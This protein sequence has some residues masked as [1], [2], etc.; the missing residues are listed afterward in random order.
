MPEGPEIRLS[1]DLLADVLD[2]EVIEKISFGLPKLQRYQSVFEGQQITKVENHGKAML[3]HF[4]NGVTIY[5]HNQL[6]G[7][8]VVTQ[9][10]ILPQT[11]RQLRLALHT[12]SHSALLYSA[13]DI[14][15][16]PTDELS[17][18]PFLKKL[19]PDILATGL[20]WQAIRERLQSSRF[21][22][23]ALAA[24]YLD[25][26]FLAGI[27]NYLRSE[28]LFSAGLNPWQKPRELN[29]EQHKRLA[30]ESLLVSTQSYKTRGITNNLKRSAALK[31]QGC[32]FE[33]RRFKI[34]NRESLPCY[35]C[36]TSIVN[37]PGSNRRL[38]WCP[39]CQ[40]PT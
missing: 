9:R 5:S 25:Q 30:Q 40:P 23:R 1:A 4:D 17:E 11:N 10:D 24:L 38:Y 3:N 6:Y 36:G 20:K 19:G 22:K 14:S 27:G 29:K 37:T 28:I 13:S 26:S 31:K 35:E 39:S 16:W 21:N 18:H 34:F 2:G 15:V 7:L 8:W 12:N 32:S 33:Q